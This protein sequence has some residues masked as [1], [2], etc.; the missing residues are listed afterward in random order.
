MAR[1]SAGT[2]WLYPGTNKAST[3][4]FATRIKLGMGCN[5]YNALF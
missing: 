1:D 2:L 3:S 4:L 5:Q